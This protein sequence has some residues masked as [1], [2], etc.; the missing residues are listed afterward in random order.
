MDF[1]KKIFGSSV[2]KEISNTYPRNIGIAM[3]FK[4]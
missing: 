2:N 1:L 3:L 4:S